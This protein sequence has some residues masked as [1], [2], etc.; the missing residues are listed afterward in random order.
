M[1]ELKKLN[2]K[3]LLVEVQL[4]ESKTYHVLGNLPKARAALTSTRTTANSIYVPPQVK[5]QL[6]LQVDVNV[7]TSELPFSLLKRV[8]NRGHRYEMDSLAFEKFQ[9]AI[10]FKIFKFPSNE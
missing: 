7:F 4:L 10:S 1:K 6:D 2:D 9:N 5:A 3:N 8:I